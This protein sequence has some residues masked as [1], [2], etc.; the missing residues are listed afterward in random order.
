MN[1]DCPY[2]KACINNKCQD[3]CYGACGLNA[4]C[5]VINHYPKCICP[6]GQTGNP[7]IA[8]HQ[9]QPPSECNYGNT[10]TFTY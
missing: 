2:N 6:I 1:S 9:P 10:E 3:P 7:L 8:C 4:E 5:Q